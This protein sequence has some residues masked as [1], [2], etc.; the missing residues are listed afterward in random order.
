MRWSSTEHDTRGQFANSSALKLDLARGVLCVIRWRLVDGMGQAAK[1]TFSRPPASNSARSGGKG[2]RTC[3]SFPVC[4]G[5][6]GAWDY[7]GVWGDWGS[8]AGGGKRPP[9]PSHLQ[10]HLRVGL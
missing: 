3:L 7:C 4:R 8:A 2:E 10:L 9:A 5:M 1:V 6:C